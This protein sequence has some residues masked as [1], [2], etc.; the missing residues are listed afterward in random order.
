MKVGYN[1]EFYFTISHSFP[2][3]QIQEWRQGEEAL[4]KT[5]TFFSQNEDISDWLSVTE[6][7]P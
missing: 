6:M 2:S 5:F 7:T 1:C 4:Y 3:V